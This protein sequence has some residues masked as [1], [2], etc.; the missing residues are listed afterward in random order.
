MRVWPFNRSRY[1]VPTVA[2]DS[3]HFVQEALRREI[4]DV[5]VVKESETRGLA[6]RWSG[7]LLVE[8]A[9]A[10][11]TIEP[12]FQPYGFTPFLK[13]EGDVTWIEALPLANVV[14][15]RRPVLSLV[16][17][18]LTVISTLVAGGLWTG[19]L[20]FLTFNPFVQ[21]MKL[22]D[23]APFA[24]T[25]LG[26]LGTHEFGHYFT[27]RSYGASVSLPYFIPAP[28]PLPFG[29]LGAVIVM[30][31]PA[32]DRNSLFDIAVA[33][34][35]A[36]L[37]VAVPAVLLGLSWSR[38]GPIPPD[39]TTFGDSLLMRLLTYLVFGRIPEGMDVFIHPVA[40]AGW[41]GLFVTA[42]NLFPVG[43]LD[44]GRIAYALFGA[45]H[46]QVSIA[47]F[48]GLLALGAAFQSV[49]WIVFAGL[50]VLL[51]GFH[52]APPLDDLTPLSPRR[53]AVGVFCLIL[54]V[55]LIPPIPIQ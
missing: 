47:T 37:V 25:L 17:F 54:L 41:V 50:V 49:N 36:G 51:I 12:R 38:V 31:S 22:L 9:R 20:P 5:L 18:I 15:R 30:R 33:G 10:L 13:R 3:L 24:V 52:H 14:A 26:I 34:P 45:W 28:P 29:T 11:T 6:L 1:T 27:A 46:R 32:R 55:L 39:A 23:G 53:Y 7:T 35:L 2:S 48:F 19:S 42:L 16:L 40:L 8:P 44:G 4:E 43:Q 21:P